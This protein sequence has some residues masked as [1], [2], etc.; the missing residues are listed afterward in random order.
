[1]CCVSF[2]SREMVEAVGRELLTDNHKRKMDDPSSSES[3]QWSFLLCS[4]PFFL[5]MD[6]EF[7]LSPD[8]THSLLFAYGKC[9]SAVSYGL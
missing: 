4:I 9:D 5:V 1:M 2:S 3:L 7:S 8:E 6:P